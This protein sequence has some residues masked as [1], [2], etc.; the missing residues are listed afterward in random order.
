MHL[1]NEHNTL[2][3]EFK[4]VCKVKESLFW[5]SKMEELINK[6]HTNDFWD[7]WKSFDQDIQN[8]EP[9]LNDGNHIIE[10]FLMKIE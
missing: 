5:K 10:V 4:K 6:Y 2:V 7:V 8:K 9:A 3:K 1:R